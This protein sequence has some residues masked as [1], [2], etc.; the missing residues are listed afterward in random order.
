MF[1][2]NFTLNYFIIFKLLQLEQYVFY[3]EVNHYILLKYKKTNINNHLVQNL[4]N[5]R[6]QGK[7][8]LILHH[9][10]NI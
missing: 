1:I 2:I 7:Y 10:S 3:R 6:Q 9:Q 8:P 5:H 4:D